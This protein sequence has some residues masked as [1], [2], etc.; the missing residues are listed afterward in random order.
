MNPA[1]QLT[2]Q[3]IETALTDNPACKKLDDRVFVVKQLD[4]ITRTQ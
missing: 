4:A 3:R 1:E 2:A